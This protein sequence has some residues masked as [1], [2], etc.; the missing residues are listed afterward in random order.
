MSG[1]ASLALA[2]APCPVQFNRVPD[3]A[4]PFSSIEVSYDI[5]T[6]VFRPKTGDWIGLFQCDDG[7]DIEDDA[8]LVAGEAKLPSASSLG[9]QST[10]VCIRGTYT[11]LTFQ[12]APKRPDN[13]RDH[14]R[15][16]VVFTVDQINV[17]L[18]IFGH[19]YCS[20]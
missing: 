10:C 7:D 6:D 14:R 1:Y 5:D 19:Y 15:R 4:V 17:N 16:R 8:D 11:Y 9:P 20:V 18:F 3:I 2:D 13:P 12:W